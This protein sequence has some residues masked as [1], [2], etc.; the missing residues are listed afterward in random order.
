MHQLRVDGYLII[1][2]THNFDRTSRTAD[3]THI[4][5]QGESVGVLGREATNPK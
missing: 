1:L 2:I 5:R 4:L 3:R